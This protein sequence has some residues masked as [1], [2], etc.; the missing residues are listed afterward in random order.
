MTKLICIL[1]KCLAFF[2]ISLSGCLVVCVVWQV[3]SRYVLNMPSTTTDEMARFLFIWV[4]L[5]GAAYTVGQKRHLAIDLLDQ[6]L[7]NHVTKQTLLRLFVIAI[8]LTFAGVIMVF[9]G[10]KLMFNV[11]A[12][13]QVSPS[14]GIKMG[15]VYMAL[16]FSGV[17]MCL[18]LLADFIEQASGLFR[19][20]STHSTASI[21]E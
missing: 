15:F 12:S 11:L 4:G 13:G 14:L 20:T 1:N 21:S 6:M 5:M 18:Y 8:S 9:G 16:P 19:P 10:S 17:I 2:C 3:F 7:D